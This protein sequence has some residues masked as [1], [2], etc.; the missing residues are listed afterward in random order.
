MFLSIITPTYNRCDYLK[1]IAISIAGQDKTLLH[2]IEWIIIDDGSEDNTR[3]L[4][5]K[6]MIDYSAIYSIRYFYKK[7]EGKHTAINLGVRHSIG[8]ALLILDSDDYLCPKAISTIAESFK[9]D[10]DIVCAYLYANSSGKA[11]PRDYLSV[12]EFIELKGD[13]AFVFNN[14]LMKDYPFPVFLGEKF[15]TESVVWNQL[16]DLAP[17]RC[18]NIPITGGEYLDG[19][20][21][22]QYA[23]LLSSSP[24]GVLALVDTNIKLKAFSVSSVKQTAFH[25]SS[26]INTHYC[27]L[28]LKKYRNI[29]SIILIV[30]AYYVL[31]KRKV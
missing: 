13:R 30:A 23:D 15:V 31:I 11:F 10:R 1:K 3:E 28:I 4:V 14:K 26:I 19:G 22:S 5:E 8:D 12:N 2:S 24:Q 27:T 18:F 7:N 17:V 25:L 6:L 20:L 16:M 29:K 9:F 21:S